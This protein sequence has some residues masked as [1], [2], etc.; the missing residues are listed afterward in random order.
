MPTCLVILIPAVS[1]AVQ[2]CL[3]KAA[4]DARAPR[5]PRGSL[6]TPHWRGLDSN[7]QSAPR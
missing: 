1:R 2:Q 6:L 7:F 5:Q 4:L 3:F